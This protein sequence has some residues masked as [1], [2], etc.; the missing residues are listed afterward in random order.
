M[1]ASRPSIAHTLA[2]GATGPLEQPSARNTCMH[3]RLMPARRYL[4]TPFIRQP[5]YRVQPQQ[6]SGAA[7]AAATVDRSLFVKISLAGI[8]GAL[9]LSE[10]DLEEIPPE[11]FDLKGLKVCRPLT[12]G[13]NI[14][15]TTLSYVPINPPDYI[16]FMMMDTV[17]NLCT[18]M[19]SSGELL[20]YI[21]FRD[22]RLD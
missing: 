8:K 2:A 17:A 10:M 19:H 9:D 21:Y 16:R 4:C 22:A 6:A 20:T 18:F 1:L 7:A 3:A 13:C 12:S 11:I 14:L 5:L 15:P